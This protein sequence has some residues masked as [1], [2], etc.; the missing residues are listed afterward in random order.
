[1]IRAIDVDADVPSQDNEVPAGETGEMWA[2]TPQLMEGYWGNPE[3]N[4]QVLKYVDG[5]RFYRTGDLISVDKAGEISFCGRRDH[6]VKVRGYRIEL[7]GVELELG[8]LGFA[9]HVVVAVLRAHSGE[10][11]LVA[12][13]LGVTGELD[14][15]EFLR[16]AA[17]VIPAYAIPARMVRLSEPSF[18]GSGKLDRRLLREKVGEIAQQ[19]TD[20]RKGPAT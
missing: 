8:K 18:T 15:E 6:Q 1:V 3:L 16:A 5:L 19:G 2:A 13:V 9:E 17:S 7:E 4:D 12:G 11:E 20:N 10:D 14:E